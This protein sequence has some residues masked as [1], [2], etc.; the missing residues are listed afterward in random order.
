MLKTL[1][2]LE[3]KNI[4]RDKMTITMLLWPFMIGIIGRLLLEY[5]IMPKQYAAMVAALFIALTGYCFGAM[6]GFSILDD[7]D[8]LVFISISISPMSLLAYVWFKVFFAYIL[9]VLGSI[10]TISII[11]GFEL[12]LPRLI[13]VSLLSAMQAPLVAFLINAFAKNKVEGFVAVKGTGFLMLAPIIAWLFTDWKE[14]LLAFAPGFWP[15]KALQYVSLEAVNNGSVS[16]NLG[17]YGYIMLG[18]VWCAIIN[19]LCY[20]LFRNKNQL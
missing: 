4:L 9:G 1:V 19:Y 2:R 7:R 17:F 10:V 13:F 11:G 5:N 18:I 14:W 20:L 16:M 12:S 8:D 15:V 6:A 3:L